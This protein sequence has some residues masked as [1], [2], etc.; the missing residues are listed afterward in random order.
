M[1]KIKGKKLLD[2]AAGDDEHRDLY[3]T[4]EV[5]DDL[6]GKDEEKVIDAAMKNFYKEYDDEMLKLWKKKYG[7]DKT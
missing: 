7:K 5:S 6:Y 3:I 1:D 4:V 2:Y